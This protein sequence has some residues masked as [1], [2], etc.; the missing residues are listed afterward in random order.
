MM[1]NFR[2]LKCI[3]TRKHEYCQDIAK[4]EREISNTNTFTERETLMM[5][6]ITAHF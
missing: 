1:E 6:D 4:F 5:K 2:C 3:N